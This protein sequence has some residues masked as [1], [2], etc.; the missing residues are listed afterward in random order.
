M[1]ITNIKTEE[2]KTFIHLFWFLKGFFVLYFHLFKWQFDFI[3]KHQLS[4]IWNHLLFCIVKHMSVCIWVF[5]RLTYVWQC[6]ISSN[7]YDYLV[8]VLHLM[9]KNGPFIL[10][11]SKNLTYTWLQKSI[12]TVGHKILFW[13]ICTIMPITLEFLVGFWYICICKTRST[14]RVSFYIIIIKNY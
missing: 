9:A 5:L 7:F 3:Q 14:I 13:R 8:D 12:C 6:K 2:E 10:R 4:N 11:Y 1:S